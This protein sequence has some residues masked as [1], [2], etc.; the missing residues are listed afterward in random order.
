VNFG[1]NGPCFRSRPSCRERRVAARRRSSR[2]GGSTAAPIQV[3][4]QRRRPRRERPWRDVRRLVGEAVADPHP[5]ENAVGGIAQVVD[6][7]SSSVATI[8]PEPDTRAGSSS[9]IRRELR[10]EAE[11]VPD[12]EVVFAG[13]EDFDCQAVHRADVLQ[14]AARCA[15]IRGCSSVRQL[16]GAERTEADGAP[17]CGPAPSARQRRDSVA[18]PSAATAVIRTSGLPPKRGWRSRSFGHDGRGGCWSSFTVRDPAA[19]TA[20][21]SASPLRWAQAP[22]VGVQ[23]DQRPQACS[24]SASSR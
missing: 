17:G 3:L 19:A 9:W 23:Q 16:R 18:L 14:P 8:E 20:V 21:S 12:L 2:C 15:G 1:V 10:P 24:H 11:L 6:V 7:A 22:A 5:P 13:A 4:A